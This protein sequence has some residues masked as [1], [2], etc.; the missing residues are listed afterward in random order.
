MQV[1]SSHFK[2]HSAAFLF[3]AASLLY[4]A[5]P[6]RAELPLFTN[7]DGYNSPFAKVFERVAPAVVKVVIRGVQESR[8]GDTPWFFIPQDKVR[9]RPYSGMG[10]GVVID[11]DGHIIT[12]NH[13]IVKPDGS[14]VADKILVIFS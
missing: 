1:F 10:S 7:D 14:S 9:Q 11:R 13:V 3:L 5:A 4:P 2:L 8:S 6:S 12:N